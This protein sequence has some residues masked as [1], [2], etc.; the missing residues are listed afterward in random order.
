MLSV[1]SI[2]KIGDDFLTVPSALNTKTP[3]EL[4]TSEFVS[5]CSAY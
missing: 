2:V 4:D 3:I 1:D 5:T